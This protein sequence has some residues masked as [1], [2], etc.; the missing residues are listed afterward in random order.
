MTKQEELAYL[1]GI[2]QEASKWA[3]TPDDD[4]DSIRLEVEE[5][6]SHLLGSAEVVVEGRLQSVTHPDETETDKQPERNMSLYM[7]RKESGF[8]RVLI[9]G[10]MKWKPEAECKKDYYCGKRFRWVWVGPCSE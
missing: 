6:I 1:V 3:R 7:L 2:V 10:H 5:R 9:D 8:V 4:R